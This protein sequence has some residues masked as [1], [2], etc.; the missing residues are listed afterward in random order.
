MVHAISIV[1]KKNKLL[2]FFFFFL[3]QI[4][5]RKKSDK[6]LKRLRFLFFQMNSSCFQMKGLREIHGL[7]S[8][9]LSQYL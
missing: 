4:C 8:N 6:K 1:G 5:F 9:K 3:K 7:K 2:N